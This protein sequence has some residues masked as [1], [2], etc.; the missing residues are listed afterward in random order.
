V[1]FG[2]QKGSAEHREGSA[3]SARKREIQLW[4]LVDDE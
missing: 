4:E 1:E 2:M 3:V